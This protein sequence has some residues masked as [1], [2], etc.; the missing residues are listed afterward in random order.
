MGCS[1]SLSGVLR[2]NPFNLSQTAESI[3][4]ALSM[5][6]EERQENHQRRHAYVMRHTTKRWAA[7]FVRHMGEVRATG[8][9]AHAH[10]IL[11]RSWRG[12]HPHKPATNPQATQLQGDLSFVQVGWGSNVR[13][14]GLRSDFSHLDEDMINTA[15]Q[16]CTKRIFLLDY[17]GTLTPNTKKKSNN[18]PSA[19][20]L[21]TL[22]MLTADDRNYVFVITGRKR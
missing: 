2:V 3:Y 19:E 21:Q 11:F 4:Q 22:R 7:G 5:T 20:L 8:M 16:T 13:L 18:K 15:Y 1:R 10:N 6:L 17:D 12:T 9:R 14:V